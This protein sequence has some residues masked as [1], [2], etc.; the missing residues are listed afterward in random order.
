M[1]PTLDRL[2]R[3][4]EA[5]QQLKQRLSLQDIQDMVTGTMGLEFTDRDLRVWTFQESSSGVTLWSHNNLFWTLSARNMPPSLNPSPSE[6]AEEQLAEAWKQYKLATGQAQEAQEALKAVAQKARDTRTVLEEALE[7]RRNLYPGVLVRVQVSGEE[8]TFEGRIMSRTT[9][10]LSLLGSSHNAPRRVFT[11]DGT[12]YLRKDLED[13]RSWI[14]ESDLPE[15]ARP[16]TVL[17]F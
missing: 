7:T 10:T 13:Y 4:R 8:H 5:G 2:Y 17:T 9:E 16:R 14:E 11:W 12:V 1:T 6:I 15:A 3:V